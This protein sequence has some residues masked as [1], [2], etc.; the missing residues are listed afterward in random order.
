MKSKNKVKKYWKPVIGVVILLGVF[1]LMFEDDEAEEVNKA[2]STTQVESKVAKVVKVEDKIKK[3]DKPVS[4]VG[5]YANEDYKVI[6]DE[7]LKLDDKKRKEIDGRDM[8]GN[9]D[10]WLVNKTVRGQAVV[11]DTGTMQYED[12]VF[13]VYIGDKPF[14]NDAQ[15]DGYY[16]EEY[17]VT[18]RLKERVT[19]INEGDNVSFEGTLTRIMDNYHYVDSSTITKN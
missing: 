11:V 8:Y 17:I 3:V 15:L 10:N 5:K 7:F 16:E 18:V 19:T 4:F 6:V 13:G 1:D 12:L 2:A 9:K 14:K